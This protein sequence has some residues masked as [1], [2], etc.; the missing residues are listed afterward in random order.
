MNE[1]LVTITADNVNTESLCC[2][3]RKKAHPGI[4]AKRA[5]LREQIPKG[6]VF[7]KIRGD[8]CAFIEYAPLEHAWVPIVGENYLYIYCLWVDGAMKRHGYGQA[9][10][11]SCL[12]DARDNGR[13]GICMLGAD[14]QKAW[15]SNQSFAARFGFTS[16][17]TT[18]NGYSLL[19]LS[20]DGTM[21][22]FSDPARKMVIP[23]KELT[24]YYDCQ[25]PFIPARIDMLRQ[26]CLAKDIPARFL[27]VDSLDMAKSLPCVFNNWAVFYSGWFVTVNQIDRG[28]VDRLVQRAD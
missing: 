5:W 12:R 17:D 15:L 7:R 20:L 1:E 24:V 23:E 21:P 26:H 9:L 14:K 3:V 8:G 6:H 25:C 16:V 27:L 19:A 11:E 10:M 13:S 2:I 22:R 18:G 28:F 4:D